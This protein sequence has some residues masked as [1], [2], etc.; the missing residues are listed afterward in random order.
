MAD[1]VLLGNTH[2]HKE[3]KNLSIEHD[4]V[5][6]MYY[7]S[8]VCYELLPFGLLQKYSSGLTTLY[9]YNTIRTIKFMEGEY[10]SIYLN[11]S[12]SDSDVIIK[13][14]TK[15]DSTDVNRLFRDLSNIRT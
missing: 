11:K 12:N 8:N 5:H 13:A 4:Y 7:I 15:E 6:R 3:D 14:E 2:A 9:S 1:G 10:L